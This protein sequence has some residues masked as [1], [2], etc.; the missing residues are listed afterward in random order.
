MHTDMVGAATFAFPPGLIA[1]FANAAP[2]I[3]A[4][5]ATQQEMQDRSMGVVAAADAEGRELTEDECDALERDA[6][7]VARLT[8]QINAR[9]LTVQAAAPAGSRRATQ[10]A[11]P[12]AGGGTRVPAQARVQNG[13]GDFSTLGDFAVSVRAAAVSGTPDAKLLNAATTYGGEGTGADGGF[14]VPPDFRR[15]IWI[16]TMADENL[17]ARCASLVTGSNNLTIPKDE[18]TSWQTTGGIQVYWEAEAATVA[19]SKPALTMLTIRLAKLMALVPISDEL[20]DDA[21]GLESWLRAKAPGK[22]ASKINTAIISGTGVGQPVGIMNSGCLITVAKETSQASLTLLFANI[23]KMWSRMYAPC[24]RNAIWLINQ[25]IEP[26]LHALA[27]DPAATSKVPAYLP[28]NGL[29]VEPYGTLMGRP[30]VPIE[31]C[32][33]LGTTGDIILADLS[34]YWAIT[35]GTQN[36][37]TDVSMHLYFDQGLQAFRFTF[38]LNGQPAWGTSVTPQN[39]TNTRSCFVALAAR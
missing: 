21:P 13:R 3:E 28:A 26:Q 38:R 30:V 32:S 33:T 2:T 36:V 20:L 14:A 22:M 19:Q 27:F 9:R 37:Q 25:D 5:Q 12:A 18:T 17:L 4:L 34:Q 35:K 23:N 7:E 8:R 1:I 6:A 24:R 11:D 29:S 31:A 39:G 15:D 16:K 10:A